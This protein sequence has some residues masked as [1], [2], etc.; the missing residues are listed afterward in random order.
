[1]PGD[2]LR[3]DIER[4]QRQAA[5]LSRIVSDEGHFP[6]AETTRL[7][8]EMLAVLAELAERCPRMH[9]ED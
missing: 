8:E 3:P 1:M 7:L 5:E 4:L 9:G 2:D 6:G